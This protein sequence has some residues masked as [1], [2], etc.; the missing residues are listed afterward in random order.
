[1]QGAAQAALCA[2]AQNK[3][4]EYAEALFATP[5]EDMVEFGLLKVARQVGLDDKALL[6]CMKSEATAA[7]LAK[8]DSEYRKAKIQK[9]FVTLHRRNFFL[10]EREVA[11]LEAAFERGLRK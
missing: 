2:E 4:T 10:G 3:G 11:E 7:R 9:Y 8:D 6:A 5:A 1:M